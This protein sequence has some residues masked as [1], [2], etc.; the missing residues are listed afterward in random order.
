VCHDS[1]AA[2]DRA[3]GAPANEIEITPEMI[4]AGVS[5]LEQLEGEASRATLVRLLG[6]AMMLAAP[7]PVQLM[8]RK[9][10]KDGN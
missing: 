8:L 9:Q 2:Y 7:L 4:E 5:L 1:A 6:E 3:T 10:T